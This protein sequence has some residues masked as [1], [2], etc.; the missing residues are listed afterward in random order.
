MCRYEQRCVQSA[1][2]AA[3]ERRNANSR[4]PLRQ[5]RVK[6]FALVASC[7]AFTPCM[8]VYKPITIR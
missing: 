7:T 5:R 6:M 1:G 2:G 8:I 4:A 3:V